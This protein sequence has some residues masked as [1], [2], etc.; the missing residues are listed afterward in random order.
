MT[1]S[2][3]FFC[4]TSKFRSDS[5]KT[6]LYRDQTSKEDYKKEYGSQSDKPC[7]R[8]NNHMILV[9]KNHTNIIY[10]WKLKMFR[11][12]TYRNPQIFSKYLRTKRNCITYT[13]LC[14]L[15]LNERH[16]CEI[17]SLHNIMQGSL[18]NTHPPKVP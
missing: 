17:S 12:Q 5:V 14:A 3:T 18:E 8:N 10:S 7:T 1:S 2:K 13:L 6:E 4:S 9:W 11:H 16:N 15:F